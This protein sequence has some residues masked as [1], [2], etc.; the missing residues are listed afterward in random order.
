M[1]SQGKKPKSLE[2]AG[3]RKVVL[4]ALSNAGYYIESF[5]LHTRFDHP[6]RHLSIDDIINGLK[7]NWR[8]CK[9]DEFND[10]EWQ[11]KYLVKTN[12]I[13]GFPLVIVVA[14]DTNNNRFTVVTSFYDD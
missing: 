10:D 6:E 7:I 8:G 5:S 2:E 9:V 11:W 14:L 3:V 13:E 1:T 12:D 4:A